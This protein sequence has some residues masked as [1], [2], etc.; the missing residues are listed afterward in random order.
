MHQQGADVAVLAGDVGQPFALFG[1]RLV[2]RLGVRGEPAAAGVVVAEEPD[3]PD[4]DQRVD[5][6]GLP[7]ATVSP[8][9]G[10]LNSAATSGTRSR[11]AR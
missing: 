7:R 3:P 11:R 2:A 9:S 4:V 8:S 5:A 1:D 6:E 10:T